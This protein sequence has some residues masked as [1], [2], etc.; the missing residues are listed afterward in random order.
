MASVFDTSEIFFYFYNQNHQ[1]RK[2]RGIIIR[3]QRKG[4]QPT[5]RTEL[6]KKLV[7]T[8]LYSTS[9]A[10]TYCFNTMGLNAH[11]LR[12]RAN[13]ILALFSIALEST[14]PERVKNDFGRHSCWT[15]AL[16]L[17]KLFARAFTVVNG[18]NTCWLPTVIVFSLVEKLWLTSAPTAC[19]GFTIWQYDAV[20]ESPLL[21]LYKK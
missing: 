20:S 21:F 10:K 2:Q 15:R 5:L 11:G 17:P 14:S 12:A 16:T 18:S 8:D 6:K 7:Q 3:T 9:N 13:P 19:T 1:N 4:L